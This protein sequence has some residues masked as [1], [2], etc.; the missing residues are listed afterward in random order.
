MRHTSS[1]QQQ[2]LWCGACC[3][4]MLQNRMHASNDLIFYPH[5]ILLPHRSFVNVEGVPEA[6]DLV[7]RYEQ[8]TLFRAHRH[9][10]PPA[11]QPY[12][13]AHADQRSM[14]CLMPHACV[15]ECVFVGRNRGHLLSL[16]HR[17]QCSA[18]RCS[19]MQC[20]VMPLAVLPTSSPPYLQSI[21][22]PP[23]AHSHCPT[24]LC[25][26]RAPTGPP[27]YCH[28]HCLTPM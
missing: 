24:P 15:Y 17:L 9:I 28:H 2:Q 20:S 7:N 27:N 21:T 16:M 19:V 11:A 13:C 6:A 10:V 23:H 12:R 25:H 8:V 4:M 26:P 18:V 1:Q 5:L 14:V 3:C 22:A